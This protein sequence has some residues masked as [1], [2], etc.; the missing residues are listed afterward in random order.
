MAVVPTAGALVVFTSGA[1]KGAVVT[2]GTVVVTGWEAVGVTGVVE[3]F[4]AV[5]ALNDTEAFVDEES[6]SNASNSGI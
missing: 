6:K 1:G 5:V 2:T 3:T 4:E